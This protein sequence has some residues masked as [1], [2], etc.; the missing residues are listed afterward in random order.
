MPSPKP[1]VIPSPLISLLLNVSD[2][3]PSPTHHHHMS[4]SPFTYPKAFVFPAPDS[5]NI[6]TLSLSLLQ[7]NVIWFPSLSGPA[8]L[9]LQHYYHVAHF[10]YYLPNQHQHLFSFTITNLPNPASITSSTVVIGIQVKTYQQH[11]HYLKS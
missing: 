4:P 10:H 1:S 8:D 7:V 2:S 3:G 6:K 9:C 5:S 11:H